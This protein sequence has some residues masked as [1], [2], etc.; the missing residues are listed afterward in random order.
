MRLPYRSRK[1]TLWVMVAIIGVTMFLYKYVE[2]RPICLFREDVTDQES[3]MVKDAVSK[4]KKNILPYTLTLF[5]PLLVPQHQHNSVEYI[6]K[7]VEGGI[8]FAL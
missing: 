3:L 1:A 7:Y 6:Y 4:R 8:L 2:F 5:L